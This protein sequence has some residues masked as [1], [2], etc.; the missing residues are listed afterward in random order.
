ML[1]DAMELAGVLRRVGASAND[2]ELNL[3][4]PGG[5]V[6]LTPA[7]LAA[8]RSQLAAADYDT[9]SARQHQLTASRA[10]QPRQRPDRRAGDA[11]LIARH[12]RL[13]RPCP[14]GQLCLRQPSLSPHPRQQ[15]TSIHTPTMPF[16]A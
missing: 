8:L 5:D 12:H 3:A 15:L 14:A 11:T 16:Q 7:G 6:E 4:R 13:R 9:L 2:E 10:E 1:A